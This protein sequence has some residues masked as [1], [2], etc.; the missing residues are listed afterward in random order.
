[1]EYSK[2]VQNHGYTVLE[3]S[4]EEMDMEKPKRCNEDRNILH[5]KQQTRSRHMR[6]SHQPNE[7]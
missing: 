6:N 4:K 5:P 2:K 3:E 1:M 7:H